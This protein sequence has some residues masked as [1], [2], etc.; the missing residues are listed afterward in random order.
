MLTLPEPPSPAPSSD[1][2][3]DEAPPLCPSHT[4]AQSDALSLPSAS[5]TRPE[6][7][8]ETVESPRR[9]SAFKKLLHRM[10]NKDLALDKPDRLYRKSCE[11]T[12][13]SAS[14]SPVRVDDRQEGT[15][16]DGCECLS[17][18]DNRMKCVEHILGGDHENH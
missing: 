9:H 11:P 2:R 10:G 7:N 6:V 8:L 1:P 17:L 5:E 15:F 18:M 3:E 13:R 14:H 16:D 4:I 12:D